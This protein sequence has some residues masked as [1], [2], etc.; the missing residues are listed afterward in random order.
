MCQAIGCYSGSDEWVVW[1]QSN[2]ELAE[3]VWPQVIGWARN[4]QYVEIACLFEFADLDKA[5]TPEDV[6]Q[7][8][9]QAGIEALK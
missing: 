9:E 4:G 1:S 7:R 8:I 3:I 6:R 5:K 2:P